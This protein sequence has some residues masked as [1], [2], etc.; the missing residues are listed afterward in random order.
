MRK[1]TIGVLSAIT[2]AAPA[3]AET[4]EI[5]PHRIT[6]VMTPGITSWLDL[7]SEDLVTTRRRLAQGQSVSTTRLRR[8]ADLGDGFAA[9][10]YAQRLDE[11]GAANPADIAHYYGMAAATGRGGAIMNMIRYLDQVDPADVSP[12]RLALLRSIVIAYANAGNSV[13]A[14]ALVRYHWR[15]VPFGPLYDEVE[16]VLA[17]LDGELGAALSLDHSVAILQDRQRS[18]QDLLN[19]QAYLATARQST[20]LETRL[21]AQNLE[22]VLQGALAEYARYE[23]GEPQ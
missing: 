7:P 16:I 5:A 10:R 22:P 20:S 2:L 14:E 21:V 8:L 3:F 11:A 6:V 13:A 15:Q 19:V 1:I 9:L 17:R 23:Q 18:K 12:Q 4:E